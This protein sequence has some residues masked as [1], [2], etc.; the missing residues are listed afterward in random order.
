LKPSERCK[1]FSSSMT[2]DSNRRGLTSIWEN[3]AELWTSICLEGGENS[4]DW[5]RSFPRAFGVL[6]TVLKVKFL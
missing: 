1:N 2:R 6:A 4:L 3:M 5:A